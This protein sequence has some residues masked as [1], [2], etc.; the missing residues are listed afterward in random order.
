MDTMKLISR[1]TIEVLR[2]HS[3]YFR[4]A[5]GGARPHQKLPDLAKFP[6]LEST[7]KELEFLRKVVETLLCVCAQR[8]FLEC[9]PV[10]IIIR[11]F[12]VCKIIHPNI[13][14]MCE[15]DYINQKLVA[16][17][18]KQEVTSKAAQKRYA[19]S[20]TYEAFMQHIEKC[21]DISELTHIRELIITDILQVSHQSF[22][23]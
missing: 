17:L 20:E 11:E 9:S 4:K 2:K 6:Y 15:P 3:I 13:D 14:K 19:H 23:C 22:P 21:E 18:K 8:E 5:Q 1:D 16:Y 10:R 12:L 7:E